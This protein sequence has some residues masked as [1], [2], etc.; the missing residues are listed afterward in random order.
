M[1]YRRSARKFKFNDG[2]VV[3]AYLG[4][5]KVITETEV[6]DSE[7]PLLLSKEAIK[8]AEMT[9]DLVNDKVKILENVV[10]LEFASSGH[11]TLPLTKERSLVIKDPLSIEDRIS[12]S[13]NIQDKLYKEK[14]QIT[15]K[16]HTQFGHPSLD[17]LQK[18]LKQAGVNGDQFLSNLESIS[19]DCEICA[20]YKRP[21]P[22]PVVGFSL[23]K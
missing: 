8:K 9:I 19:F 18:L 2:R 4:E 5:K 20:K 1:S 14:F 10:N 11:Y 12:V 23:A 7:L 17:K 16:L 22:R 6:V 3:Q 21:N 15:S 13:L